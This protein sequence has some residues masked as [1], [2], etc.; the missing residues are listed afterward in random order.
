VEAIPATLQALREDPLGFLDGIERF[1]A[2]LQRAGVLD[3]LVEALI[4]PIERKQ[5]LNNPYDEE[6]NE[7]LHD[8][9][10]AR[11]YQ[12]YIGGKLATTVLSAGIGKAVKS[13]NTARKFGDIIGGTRAGRLIDLVNSKRAA[14]NRKVIGGLAKGGKKAGGAVLS[15][16]KTVGGTIRLYRLKRRADVDTSDLDEY[17]S[18]MVGS[19][20]RGGGDDA[21]DTVDDLDDDET[22]DA[23][24]IGRACTPDATAASAY[25]ALARDCDTEPGEPQIK[26]LYYAAGQKGVD[27]HELFDYLHGLNRADRVAIRKVIDKFEGGEEIVVRTFKFFDQGTTFP[28]PGVVPSPARVAKSLDQVEEAGIE[29]DPEVLSILRDGQKKKLKGRAYEVIL[30]NKYRKTDRYSVKSVG[31][32]IEG[33][34]ADIVMYDNKNNQYVVVEAKNV[35]PDAGTD[36]GDDDDGFSL[37]EERGDALAENLGEK[38]KKYERIEKWNDVRVVYRTTST[39]ERFWGQLKDKI[40]ELDNVKA[41]YD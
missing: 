4:G 9:F 17:E 32:K 12:G 11:W 3:V 7:Q 19:Y 33:T 40:K 30:A 31:K 1:I 34:D 25:A 26:Q 41:I 20:L 35:N 2:V 6:K 15:S 39:E 8:A 23:F 27:P 10:A 36:I 14:V 13:S 29:I 38:I 5:E 28:G 21:A 24:S 18:T 16:A 22:D 37:R